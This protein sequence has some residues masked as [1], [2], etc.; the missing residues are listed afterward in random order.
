MRL[1]QGFS[2]ARIA[3]AGRDSRKTN[4]AINIK[5]L[6]REVHNSEEGQLLVVRVATLIANDCTAF[7]PRRFAEAANGRCFAGIWVRC[8]MN[9]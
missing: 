6:E 8:G 2:I 9:Q 4:K 3:R 1:A 5:Y 7:C